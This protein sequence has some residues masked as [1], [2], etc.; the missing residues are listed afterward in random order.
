MVTHC[1][2]NRHCK[3]VN[4]T[5]LQTVQNTLLHISTGYLLDTNIQ[6]LHDKIIVIPLH[7]YLK[8]LQI[9][10]KSQHPLHCLTQLITTRQKKKTYLTT[11]ITPHASKHTKTSNLHTSNKTWNAYTLPL[12]S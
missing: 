5:K 8:S 7:T 9:R 4:N 11:T 6:H 3:A 1:I 12:L 10:H 2:Q